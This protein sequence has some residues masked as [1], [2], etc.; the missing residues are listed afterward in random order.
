[1]KVVFLKS[2]PGGATRGDV[3]NV[4]EGYARNYLFP[5]KIALPATADLLQELE[6][7]RKNEAEEAKRTS[8]QVED[9][10][11]RVITQ[12]VTFSSKANSQGKLFGSVTAADIVRRVQE[13]SSV[14]LD[15]SWLDLQSP[16][17]NVG[18]VTVNISVPGLDNKHIIIRIQPA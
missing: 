18:E 8:Q 6:S 2:I 17:R 4:R 15:P 13:L 7:K 10:L 11:D 16:L 14:V 3:R 5:R 1:M 12:P 9:A